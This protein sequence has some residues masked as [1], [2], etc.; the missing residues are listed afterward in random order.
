M[1][2]NILML[3]LI[4]ALLAAVLE[5]CG[6]TAKDS[7]DTDLSGNKKQQYKVVTASAYAPFC[8]LNES[9]ELDGYDVDICKAIDNIDTEIE[10]S[11][12]W[13]DWAS[14][15]PGLDAGRYDL[16][17]YELGRNEAREEMY[18]YG[19]VPYSNAAGAAII[20]TSKNNNWKS[21]EDI[22]A[23]GNAKIGCIVGAN[24]TKYVEDYLNKNPGA[25]EIAY[26]E[27]EI[28]AVL[29]DVVNG[30]IDA[31]INAGSVA[32]EKAKI[33]GIGDKLLVSGY[34]TDPIPVWF[35]YPKSDRGN[36]LSDEIDADIKKLYE[37]GTLS[38]ISKKWLG[39]DYV[40]KSLENSEYF[41]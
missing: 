12:E 19:N 30:R 14:M 34:V 5:G 3:V 11:Y 22:K 28:D 27:T 8:Y 15:L 31:T 32:M 24:Y 38:E 17:T 33:S 26:Y 20:T 18:H 16:C 41:K 23:A 37:D 1:K 21:F 13:C 35:I 39:D 2:K 36:Q 10:F 29:E 4:T 25:F 9:D 7:V 6:S 40:I